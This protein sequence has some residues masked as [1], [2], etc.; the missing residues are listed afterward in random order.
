[1]KCMTAI[2]LL[3][4]TSAALPA[5]QAGPH[6]VK[7]GT[8]QAAIY[9]P[10]DAIH[11]GK[12]LSGRLASWTGAQL[13]VISGEA[14]PRSDK[15]LIA[16]GTPMDNP[17]VAE[18]TKGDARFDRLG[19]EGFLLRL[20]RVRD[21]PVLIGAGRTV[22]GVNNAVSDLLSWRLRLDDRSASIDGNPDVVDAPE[23]K[24]RILWTWDGQLNW[25]DSV[26]E[27]HTIQKGT[28]GTSVVPYT[29]DGFLTHFKAA[30][31]FLSDHKFNGYIVWGFLR[32]EHGGVEAGR[33]ISRYA[34]ERNVRMLPGVCTQAAYGGFIFSQH[35]RYSLIGWLRDQPQLCGR[36]KDGSIQAEAICPS[37]PEN[38]QWLREGTRWLLREC[39]DIGGVNLENGDLMEC[40][41]ADCVAA[42][43]RP[44][45]D[46]NFLWDMM[47]TEVPV[48]EEIKRLRPDLWATFASYVGFSESGLRHLKDNPRYPPRFLK[49]FPAGSICQ[50]TYTGMTD[51]RSWPEGLK[52][53]PGAF[54]DHIG[55]LHHGSI[56]GAPVDPKR[57]WSAPAA[58]L[59]DCSTAIQFTCRRV[60][61]EQLPGLVIK[62]QTGPV[63]PAN[64]IN[65]LAFEYFSWHPQ[66]SYDQF[67]V[68]RLAFCYGDEALAR[69]FVKLLHNTTRDASEVE[70]DR[71]TAEAISQRGDL[72]VRQQRR[73]RNLA[74]ELRRRLAILENPESEETFPTAGALL[75]EAEQHAVRPRG[76]QDGYV[77]LAGPTLATDG[78]VIAWGKQDGKGC[79]PVGIH[80]L[81]KRGADDLIEARLRIPRTDLIWTQDGSASRLELIV[82]HIDAVDDGAVSIAD[83]D[84]PSLGLIGNYRAPGLAA[85]AGGRYVELDVTR[86]V[87]ADLDAGRSSFA[88]RIEPSTV[89]DDVTSQLY[90]PSV[91]NTD[92]AF[93]Q[94]NR[95]AR[96]VLRWATALSTP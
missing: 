33:E 64:E 86:Q 12:R 90:F 19:D 48:I 17:L 82:Q 41:C 29:V 78:V 1:M 71:E 70:A 96:L 95:G 75:D 52:P 85:A 36:N 63:S 25:S 37:K 91:E 55:L 9:A 72:E 15:L 76:P 61:E 32:D 89:P 8:A 81:P 60:A 14:P 27:M 65:Y 49:Q 92:Q 31:D 43:A 13:E 35:N 74:D 79:V 80:D 7:D 20:G 6:L 24:Y 10:G 68:D 93:P 3:A 4:G 51:P 16:L 40:Y 23:L 45:N 59:D 88:W 21:R 56:W 50:W 18:A 28:S 39:P 47:Y 5:A 66:R 54:R 58:M 62:G 22:V 73:W 94:A 42:K 53:P 69:Q 2:A 30:V 38:Q 77:L 34:K 46:P 11:A 83:G 26:A 57:W 67:V 84:S 44:E 87:R